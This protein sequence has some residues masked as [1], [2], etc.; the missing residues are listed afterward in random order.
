MERGPALIDTDT[1]SEVMKGRDPHVLEAAARYLR[2]WNRFHFSIL[3]RYEVLRGLEAKRAQRQIERFQNRCAAST[4]IPLDPAIVDRAAFLY[5][6][7]RRTGRP[8]SDA[9]ILIAATALTLEVPVVTENRSHF[10]RIPGLE[11]ES[12]RRPRV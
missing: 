10:S 9:D 7:L 6:E 12:W 3:T 8:I 2:R 11:I 5:G 4:I 1:L